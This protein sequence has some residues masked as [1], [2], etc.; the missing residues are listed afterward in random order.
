MRPLEGDGISGC[1][2]SCK[3]QALGTSASEEL[4]DLD[5]SLDVLKAA[6]RV[7]LIMRTCS[8]PSP[9]FILSKVES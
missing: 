4:P 1:I 5:L 6:I 8:Q 2:E 3:Y 9:A 7:A